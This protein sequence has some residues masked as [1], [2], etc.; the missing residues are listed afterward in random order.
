M[1][2]LGV[3]LRLDGPGALRIT[4]AER[5]GAAL[6][7]DE[8]LVEV[9]RV[10]LCGSDQALYQ[11]SYGGPS[12]YPL[13]FGHE[14]AGRVVDTGRRGTALLGRWVTGDC[15]RWCGDCPRCDQDRNVCGRIEKFGLTVDGFSTRLRVVDRRYLYPDTHD[16]GPG[17]LALSEFF[18]VAE[19]GL[20]R[21]RPAA[22]DRTL[23]VG[24][25]ALGLASYLLLTG[26]YQAT[27][28]DLLEP[29][30]AKAAAV[31]K[32]FP[33]ARVYTELPQ[34]PAAARA[35][36]GYAALTAAARYALV[37]D[38]S[39]GAAGL[40][41][42]LTVALPLGRVLC[43]GLRQTASV[44]TD[45]LVAKGLTLTG[46][47]GGTGSFAQAQAFLSGHREQAGLLVTHTWPAEEAAAA[48][49][50]DDR[51]RIK[52]QLTFGEDAR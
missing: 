15:S 12:S 38:C 42:A 44:R 45:L 36:G 13:R 1:S 14:W 19:H 21:V 41:T 10:T 29:D 31:G 33:S 8:V 46:S 28:L 3:D 30:P 48:F 50:S 4:P 24:A 22:G 47:I 39:S 7:P 37:V 5:P 26:S 35:A 11:G 52:T 9:D 51:T 32:L 34:P 25:G 40:D 18:A 43:F 17:L 27:E 2:D 16:L 49:E 23:V 20:R 6:G